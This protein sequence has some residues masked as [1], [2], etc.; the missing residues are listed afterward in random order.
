MV[1]GIGRGLI[2]PIVPRFLVTSKLLILIFAV[3]SCCSGIEIGYTVVMHGQIW[4]SFVR[5]KSWS[6]RIVQLR[7]SGQR[8]RQ[9]LNHSRTSW[10]C[11]KFV[12]KINMAVNC[13][14]L[15]RVVCRFHFTTQGPC[16][17]TCNLNTRVDH[18]FQI[19]ACETCLALS[20]CINLGDIIS[21]QP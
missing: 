21:I 4:V 19:C 1:R 15:A 16:C 9:T 7:C 14:H 12:L 13:K 20:V 5:I 3:G 8:A 17:I 10:F 18:I 11:M 6:Y 2:Y